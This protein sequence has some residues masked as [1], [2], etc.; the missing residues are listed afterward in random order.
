LE[1]V[2]AYP[3]DVE[4]VVALKTVGDAPSRAEFLAAV[5]E[6]GKDGAEFTNERLQY[7]MAIEEHF[8]S[9][10]L[11]DQIEFL[12][13]PPPITEPQREFALSIQRICL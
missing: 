10:L 8:Q 2:L 11:Y 5:R 3:P 4:R 12:R 9:L 1:T 7:L 6:Y 13:S